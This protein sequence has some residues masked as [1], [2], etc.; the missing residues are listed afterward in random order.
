MKGGGLAEF[1]GLGD[2]FLGD[3]GHFSQV[4]SEYL[5]GFLAKKWESH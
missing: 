2:E 3:V 4:N 1:L 5:A